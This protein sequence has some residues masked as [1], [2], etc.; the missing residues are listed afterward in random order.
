MSLT[1]DEAGTLAFGDTEFSTSEFDRRL[2]VEGGAKILSEMKRRGIVSRI[3]R[4][5]Y[6]FLSPSERPDLRSLE[7]DRVRRILLE[8]P[9]PKAWA[10]PTA[11]EVWTGGGYA[12]SPSAFVRVFSVA[13][14]ERSRARW[15]SYLLKKGISTKPRKRIGARVELLPVRALKFVNVA[16]EPVI[17]KNEVVSL[18]RGSPSIFA[19]AEELLVD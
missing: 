8:G 1:Y 19:G 3:G 5:R 6:R 9:N 18:I 12:V 17:P 4:G 16:G 11:V 2:G 13:I 10:G 15:G 14:P 7:W